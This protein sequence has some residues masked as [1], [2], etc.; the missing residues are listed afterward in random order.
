MFEVN[1]LVYLKAVFWLAFFGALLQILNIFMRTP[2]EMAAHDNMSEML[3]ALLTL[4]VCM[5]AMVV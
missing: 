1:Y 3:A 5:Y 4:G 2:Q